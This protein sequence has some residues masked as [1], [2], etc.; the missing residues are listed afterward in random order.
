MNIDQVRIVAVTSGTKAEAL[1]HQKEN[2]ANVPLFQQLI[3]A[4]NDAKVKGILNKFNYHSVEW[5]CL[6]EDSPTFQDYKKTG[7]PLPTVIFIDVLYNKAL[8]RLDSS[9]Q[10]NS[11]N[12][13]SMLQKMLDTEYIATQGQGGKGEVIVYKIPSGQVWKGI[14]FKFANDIAQNLGFDS[15][16][17]DFPA[18]CEMIDKA[19]GLFDSL[20]GKAKGVAWLGLAAAGAYGAKKSYDKKRYYVTAAA[21]ALTIFAGVGAYRKL[22]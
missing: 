19:D 11:Y 4:T 15:F 18:L 2:G 20:L 14:P 5:F 6:H 21:S 7:L 3:K 10:V 17:S 16:C 13:A 12:V 1:Q 22:K 8:W 9:D